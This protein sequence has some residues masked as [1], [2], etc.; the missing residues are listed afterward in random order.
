MCK[1]NIFLVSLRAIWMVLLQSLQ[2]YRLLRYGA[3]ASPILSSK[4]FESPEWLYWKKFLTIKNGKINN[5][6]YLEKTQL[7]VVM[8]FHTDIWVTK[9]K[10][11]DCTHEVV[12][13][14]VTV[15]WWKNPLISEII[16]LSLTIA[17]RISSLK[18][19]LKDTHFLWYTEQ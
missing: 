12:Y 10:I 16:C 7:A 18:V 1:P 5:I 2:W 4:S 19:V 17:F 14:L 6:Q 9:V 11:T 8:F 15:F 3:T 13:S